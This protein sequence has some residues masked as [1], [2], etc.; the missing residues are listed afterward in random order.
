MVSGIWIKQ[1]LGLVVGGGGGGGGEVLDFATVYKTVSRLY[2]P[3]RSF[4]SRNLLNE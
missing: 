2:S 3:W 1:M 4:I